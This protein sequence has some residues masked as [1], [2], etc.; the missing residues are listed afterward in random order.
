M[1]ILL[2]I[3]ELIM[4]GERMSIDELLAKQGGRRIYWLPSKRYPKLSF[5]D[6]TLNRHTVFIL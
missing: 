1:T 3:K 4:S 5:A 2:E 6:S